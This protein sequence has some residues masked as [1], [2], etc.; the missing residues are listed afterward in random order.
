A[1]SPSGTDW[2]VMKALEKDRA[3]RYE[4]ANGLARDVQRHLD[5]DPVEA[6]PPSRV[7]RLPKFAPKHPGGLV[8]VSAV[9]RALVGAVSALA[10][11]TAV[12][13][14]GRSEALRELAR[15]RSERREMA[16]A[17]F[18][19]NGLFGKALYDID[20]DSFDRQSWAKRKFEMVDEAVRFQ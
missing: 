16:R 1:P 18:R 11:S 3:R 17:Y 14:R 7:Y 10:V 4:T 20:N 5:G 19:Q 9:I 12:V 15:V 13:S 2:V 6:G 8:A